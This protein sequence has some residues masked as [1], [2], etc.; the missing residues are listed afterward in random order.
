MYFTIGDRGHIQFIYFRTMTKAGSDCPRSVKFS[1]QRQ[2]WKNP[3]ED[4]NQPNGNDRV[5]VVC[6]RN[7]WKSETT[8]V[9]WHVKVVC[10]ESSKHWTKHSLPKR[11]PTGTRPASLM[12]SEVCKIHVICI[13][14][15]GRTGTC[16]TVT[17][18]PVSWTCEGSISCYMQ[19]SH[20]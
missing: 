1:L 2:R 5:P 10:Q 14:L 11:F 9:N 3:Q 13:I 19:S 18:S 15:D 7:L 4:Q 8:N 16:L 12:P 6:V 17:A 20:I